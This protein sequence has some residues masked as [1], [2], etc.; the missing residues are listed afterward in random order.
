M[1]VVIEPMGADGSIRL[2]PIGKVRTPVRGQQTGGFQDVESSIE[3][4]PEFADYL[5]GLG[6]Y[7]HLIVMYWMHQQAAPKAITRP[8]GH[9][10]V[11]EV[12]M[13]ACR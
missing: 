12:G 5:K 7:S 3:L 9:P 6:E 4:A 13:F 2:H 1:S 8:Q 10:A 11:P